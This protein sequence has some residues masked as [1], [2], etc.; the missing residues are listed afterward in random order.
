MSHL[1]ERG[2]W[3]G[4]LEGPARSVAAAAP[5]PAPQYILFLQLIL[6]PGSAAERQKRLRCSG[7]PLNE[8]LKR[9]RMFHDAG[10]VRFG[11]SNVLR[12]ER[13]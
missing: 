4:P 7:A 10:A 3:G 9:A 8:L 5:A 6:P 12:A 2:G 11:R 13:L 1:S